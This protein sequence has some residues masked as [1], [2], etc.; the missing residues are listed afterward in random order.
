[1]A[2]NGA[3]EIH[4]DAWQTDAYAYRRAA[5]TLAG[6]ALLGAAPHARLRLDRLRPRRPA[7][8]GVRRRHRTAALHVR[9]ERRST[10]SATFALPPRQS[11]PD[12]LFQ[13]FT[14]GGYFYLDNQDRVVTSTTT[15]HILVIAETPG[16]AGFTQLHDYDLSS[17]LSAGENITSALPD[18]HGLL[19]FVTKADGIV[20]TLNF[21][22]GA[23]HAIHLGHGMLGEIE[24]SFATDM[25]GGVYIATNRKLYRFVA[26]PGG[27]PQVVWQV[28]YPNSF[29]HKPGQVDDGTGTTPTVMPGGF[30]NITD[31]A[32][33]M[34]IVVYRTAAHPSR[35]VTVAP[36]RHHRR[37]GVRVALPR[38]VCRVPVFAKGRQRRRELGDR[39]RTRDDRRE[40][41]RLQR[42]RSR[43]PAASSP[44][45][46]SSASISTANGMGCHTVW[47]QHHR[48]RARPSS[49]S[50]RSP[51]G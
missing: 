43:S 37:C 22:S 48:A 19:W 2:A 7:R 34:D 9:P 8:L 35:L 1:M 41:L 6:D 39:R 51:P 3:S 14:G 44:H 36:D 20:G 26:G 21:A 23:I 27:V 49:P 13:D 15:H 50:C 5:R 17:M 25:Y 11:L 16:G 33:P 24:N 40:Q 18:S 4:D 46:G 28:T 31:N 10:R 42:L 30:V 47:T 45:P 29:E 38:E 32:D 12:N